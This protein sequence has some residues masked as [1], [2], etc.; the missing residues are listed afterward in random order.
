MGQYLQEDTFFQALVD[1]VY[2]NPFGEFEITPKTG[3]HVIAFGGI[4][5]MEGKFEKLL[6]FYREGLKE[7]GWKKYKTI[8]I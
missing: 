6:V 8:N 7:N 4:E 1:E 3:G 2:V 5:D